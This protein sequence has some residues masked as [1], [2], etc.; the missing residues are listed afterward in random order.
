[1]TEVSTLIK[2]RYKDVVVDWPNVPHQLFV[3]GLVEV[4]H[5]DI[6]PLLPGRAGACLVVR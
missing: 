4:L 3:A 6:V 2:R 1:M 5:I